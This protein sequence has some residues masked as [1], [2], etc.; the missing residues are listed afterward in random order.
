MEATSDNQ[1]PAKPIR[2][3]VVD[4]AMETR[5]R[6]CQIV[7]DAPGMEVVGE[8][9]SGQGAVDLC[10]DT[11]PDV[12]LMDLVMPEMGGLHATE[13][14]AQVSPATR[15]LVVSMHNN[16]IFIRAALDSGATGYLLKDN[17][18]EELATAIRTVAE[19]RLYLTTE[20]VPER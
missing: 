5:I 14:I 4:D 16:R 9:D 1:T 11:Q 12:A 7:E 18:Y 17:A 15:I 6:I 10:R 19:G 13:K 3:V 8:A 2:V 20:G